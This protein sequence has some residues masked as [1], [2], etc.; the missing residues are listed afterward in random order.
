MSDGNGP[1][2]GDAARRGPR[3]R[4]RDDLD[5]LAAEEPVLA[6]VRD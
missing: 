4:R 3:H 1:L 2:A 6:A 5:L